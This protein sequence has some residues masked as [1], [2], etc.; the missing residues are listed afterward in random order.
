[1][2]LSGGKDSTYALAR[3]TDMGLRVLAFTLDNGYISKEAKENIQRV[4]ETLKVDH[5]YGQTDAMNAIFVDSLQRHCNVCDGCFKTIYTLSI[6]LALEKNIPYIVTGLSRGQFFETRLTEE[7]FAREDVDI[8]KIDETILNAR[9]AYHQVDDAVKRL[10]DVSALA[11]EDTFKKVQFIDFYRYSDISLADM[12]TYLDQQLPWVRPTDTGRSTNCLINK[13]G[14][15]VH[16]KQLG[17]SNYA[18]PYS[19]DVRI[20]HKTR[21][22]SLEEIN[23]EIDPGE[24]EKILDEIGFTSENSKD[25]E[26]LVAYVTSIYP[27]TEQELRN[28]LLAYLPEYMVPVQFIQIDQIPMTVNSKVDYD[29]LPLPDAVRPILTNAYFE[30]ATE[31]EQMVTEIWSEI[32]QIDR[33][34]IHDTFLEIG[35]DSLAGIRIM[36]RINEAFALELPV[37]VIFQEATIHRLANL[38]EGT[39]NSLLLEMDEP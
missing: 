39:I 35:G 24:A 31:F 26:K 17:Y 11:E 30:P 15:Y 27:V 18:F 23:E 36:A 19:W 25:R 16:K 21:E 38:L 22:A 33:I 32:L 14:I 29:A 5:V 9:M 13:A 2:L 12:L 6:N 4:V 34:G 20:G 28:H 37:N 7:L 3:L 1:M 8:S 10:L